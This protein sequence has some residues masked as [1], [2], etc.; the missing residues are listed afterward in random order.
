MAMDGIE[1]NIPNHEFM[2]G[3]F[4]RAERLTDR[5]EGDSHPFVDPEGFSAWL[6]GLL[7]NAEIKLIEEKR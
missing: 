2:G 7:A 6:D 4:E 3:V 1:V 5:K